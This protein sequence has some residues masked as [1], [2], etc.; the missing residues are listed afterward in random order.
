MGISFLS[1]ILFKEDAC[2]ELMFISYRKNN[3]IIIL[4]TELLD[5]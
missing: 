3:M 1:K 5:Q 4:T 2:Q